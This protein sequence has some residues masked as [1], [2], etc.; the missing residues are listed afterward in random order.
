VLERAALNLARRRE[1]VAASRM[2]LANG[3]C[4]L[5]GSGPRGAGQYA[6]L[7]RRQE[8]PVVIPCR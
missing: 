5:R 7:L 3:R 4:S 8:T 6:A 1:D 2:T